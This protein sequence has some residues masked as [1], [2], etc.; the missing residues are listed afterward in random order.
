MVL[1]VL[2]HVTAQEKEIKGFY[3]GKEE[4]KLSS[5]T[6]EIIIYEENLK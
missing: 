4:V 3:I 6:D 5:F 2:A 1:D